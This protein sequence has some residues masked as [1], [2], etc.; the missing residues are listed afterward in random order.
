M[1]SQYTSSSDTQASARLYELETTVSQIRDASAKT[2]L[3]H[4]RLEKRHN[5]ALAELQDLQKSHSRLEHQYFET[6]RQ[7]QAASAQLDKAQRQNNTLASQLEA[8]TRELE[9]ERERGMRR[10]AELAEQLATAKKKVTMQRRQTVNLGAPAR[11]PTMGGRMSMYA[12]DTPLSPVS[13]RF[14]FS[15]EHDG[16]TRRL[17]LKAREAEARAV[18]ME[19]AAEQVRREAQL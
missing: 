17:A 11:S 3:D 14:A 16:E 5:L 12:H 18:R 9:V 15:E 1:S 7:L 19:G 10:E 6:E 8:K 4:T 2:Q 13:E